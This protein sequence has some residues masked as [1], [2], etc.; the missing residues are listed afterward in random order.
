MWRLSTKGRG[1]EC[2]GQGQSRADAPFAEVLNTLGSE[3]VVVPL[4]RELGLHKALGSKALHGL[5]N[6]QVGDIKVLVLRRIEVLLGDQD[7]L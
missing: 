6:L 1:R 4:P 2:L 5:D 3:D 7:T